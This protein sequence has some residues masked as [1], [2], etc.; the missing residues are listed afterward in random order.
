MVDTKVSLSLHQ[1]TSHES[2][3]VDLGWDAPQMSLWEVFEEVGELSLD[4]EFQKVS[5][6]VSISKHCYPP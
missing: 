2:Q 6:I 5:S 4:G 1:L 3:P